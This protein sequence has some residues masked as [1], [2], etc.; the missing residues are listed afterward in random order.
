MLTAA[1]AVHSFMLLYTFPSKC[2]MIG[3]GHPVLWAS[4]R[5]RDKQRVRGDGSWILAAH[6]FSPEIHLDRVC[7][8][9]L[10]MGPHDRHRLICRTFTRA[11]VPHS[12]YI[13]IYLSYSSSL[14]LSPSLLCLALLPAPL[15]HSNAQ[16]NMPTP[17]AR[18]IR[19]SHTNSIKRRMKGRWGLFE[20]ACTSVCARRSPRLPD[21][22]RW[23]CRWSINELRIWCAEEKNCNEWWSPLSINI[24]YRIFMCS[25]RYVTFG[26]LRDLQNYCWKRKR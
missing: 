1:A 24:I 17:N 9:W 15:C 12:L 25:W 26:W 20:S 22:S 18:I 23:L 10:D 7:Y 5:T 13:Y 16:Q 21:F 11:R 4:A 6:G 8:H 2:T 19:V 14:S 3:G